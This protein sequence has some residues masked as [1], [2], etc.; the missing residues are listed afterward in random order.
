MQCVPG[1]AWERVLKRWRTA[2]SVLFFSLCVLLVSIG[3]AAD[4]V[5]RPA[6]VL[7]LNGDIVDPDVIDFESLPTLSGVHAVVCEPTHELK[8]QLHDYLIHHDGKYWCNVQ[9]WSGGGRH[10]DSVRQLRDERRWSEV[11][12]AETG[13]AAPGGAIRLH[14]SRLLAPRR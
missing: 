8:F 5:P 1:K 4:E 9:S 11:E 14:R 6:V 2:R 7:Q 13:D 10:A 3:V 12:S